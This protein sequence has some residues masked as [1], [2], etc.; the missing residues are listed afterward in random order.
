MQVKYPGGI[1]TDNRLRLTFSPRLA[2]SWLHAQ[3]TSTSLF[4]FGEKTRGSLLKRE[5]L[6]SPVYNKAA[7]LMQSFNH[8]SP[9]RADAKIIVVRA[10]G[11]KGLLKF[12]VINFK[13]L[14]EG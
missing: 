8:L 10:G 5:N 12:Q 1:L 7:S 13:R 3:F 9:S 6:L 14:E 4:F 2:S 11:E